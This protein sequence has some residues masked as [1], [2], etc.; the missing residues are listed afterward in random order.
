MLS[1]RWP[2]GELKK[3][4]CP[5]EAY[6]PVPPASD[7]AAWEAL[8]K[9][10][11]NRQRKAYVLG[12]AE[13]CHRQPWP[14]L[15]ATL[16]MQ[17][18]RNGNRSHFEKPY[19]ERRHRLAILVMAECFEG[20]GRFI[21]DI[22][23]GI[24]AITEEATWTVS[25][26]AHREEGD[27][28]QRQ[29]KESVALFSAQ[30][31][32]TL[33][34]ACYLLGEQ[35][36]AVSPTVRTRVNREIIRRIV[37]PMEQY[38]EDQWW[39]SGKNNW[40]PWC[41]SNILGAALY[42]L[43]DEDRLAKLASFLMQVID[44]FIDNYGED[45][46]CDEGP[47]YWGVAGGAMLVFLELLHARSGGKI[48]IYDNPKIAAMGAYIAR[49]RMDGKYGIGF[50]DTSGSV[51]LRRGIGWRYGE[52]IGNRDMM[53]AALLSMR[54]WQPDAPVWPPVITGGQDTLLNMLREIFWMDPAA[55][56]ANPER[57]TSAWL[58]D[59]QVM[60]ARETAMPDTGFV[61]AAKGGHNAENHN[62]NDLGQFMLLR[63]A[64]P[65]IID[66]GAGPYT[67]KTFSTERYDI[68]WTRGLGHNP[69]IVNGCEQQP[70]RD[71]SATDVVFADEGASVRLSMQL[72]A[73]Y[74]ASAGIDSLRREIVLERDVPRLIVRDSVS[75]AN[76]TPARIE[77]HLISPQPCVE[78]KPGRVRF[79]DTGVAL[80]VDAERCTVRIAPQP[81]DED[82]GGVPHGWGD[83]LTRISMEWSLD[84]P[85]GVCEMHFEEIHT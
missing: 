16:F 52:R 5:R 34:E 27:L 55:A 77:V 24:W 23:D 6:R 8:L 71:H 53:N 48:S 74:D 64:Q 45:G 56:P 51:N 75:M 12:R 84:A 47:M 26:H 81:M 30:T 22:I 73:A 36:D 70:G 66:T 80:S 28:L 20:R 31:A 7:R 33:A 3:L 14:V 15:P 32:M 76:D 2:E 50:A 83:T 82:S 13:S 78:E 11:L 79:G 57:E 21:D 65:V 40:A 25:A 54:G 37:E 41:A 18:I 58:K 61:V 43:D 46:G 85:E 44:R 42:M 39:I 19:F 68:W 4:F 10:D 49:V 60:I 62:H 59:I 29:D 67:R 35:L 38:P 17:F 1:E 69:P 63:D 9:D 72:A